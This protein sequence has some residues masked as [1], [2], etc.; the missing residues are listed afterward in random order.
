MTPPTHDT[1][2][3]FKTTRAGVGLALLDLFVV[4]ATTGHGR[5]EP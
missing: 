4:A 3:S 1:D 2:Q 5:G